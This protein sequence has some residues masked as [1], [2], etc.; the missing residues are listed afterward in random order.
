MSKLKSRKFL[1]TIAGVTIL[2][3]KAFM[4]EVDVDTTQLIALIGSYVIG[5]GAVDATRALSSKS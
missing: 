5:E 3:I 4:P 2:L 1:L